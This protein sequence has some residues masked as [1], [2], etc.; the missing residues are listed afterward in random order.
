MSLAIK[1]QMFEGPLDLLL[2]LID[3]AK[4]EIQDIPIHE[5]TDQY[6]AY[7]H[8]M[9]QLELDVAS[10]FLVMAATLLLI[11]SRTLLPKPPPIETYDEEWGVEVDPRE[12]LIQRLIEYRKYKEAV[13]LLKDRQQE[14]SQIFSKEPEDLTPYAPIIVEEPLRGVQLTHIVK[15][16]ERVLQKTKKGEQV[17]KIRRDEISVKERMRE[18]R[19]LIRRS[20][21]K[22]LFSQLF[23]DDVSREL[24]VV[25]FLALLELMKV[26]RIRCYQH[27]LFDDIVIHPFMEDEDGQSAD[28]DDA[29]ES[30]Y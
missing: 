9:H 19:A 3:E 14:R 7:L 17:A 15:A 24:L 18:I 12:E 27:R 25:S 1:L 13:H 23:T 30:D 28:A 16:F 26:K 4:V 10:E 8:S 2:H 11:K 29:T 20:N 21:G 22:L 5:I 6:L